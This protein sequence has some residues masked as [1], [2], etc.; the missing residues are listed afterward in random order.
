VADPRAGEVLAARNDQAFAVKRVW[1]IAAIVVAVGVAGWFAEQHYFG[2]HTRPTEVPPLIPNVGAP[3][4]TLPRPAHVIIIVEEN[5]ANSTIIGNPRAPYLNQL[6]KSGALFPNATG[7]AHPSQP[8]Y[9]ALFTGQVNLDADNC[10]EKTVPPSQPSLGGALIAARL[11]FAGFAE[12]LPRIGFTGCTS[13]DADEDYARKHA[14]W[15]NFAD[16][17]ASDNLPFSA[18]PN[19]DRLPTVAFIIPNLAHD[20]HTGSISAGD[21][22][23]RRNVAPVIDWAREHDSVVIITWDESDTLY[24]NS[25]P[26]IIVGAG[27]KSGV[28]DEAVDHYRILR[29]VEDLYGLPHLGF[30][31][32][33]APIQDVWQPHVARSR[34]MWCRCLSSAGRP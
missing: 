7:V 2:S 6:A 11:S 5:K 25:I 10:P 15:V 3:A 1:I 22:W 32:N 9:L 21:T 19:L 26:L 14:P 30:S 29:T 31:A 12:G 23:L 20:M 13:G 33:V 16:V 34:S 27:V 4:V 24:G 28:Y 17:P 8:N 18:L